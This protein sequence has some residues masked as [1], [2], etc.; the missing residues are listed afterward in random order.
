MIVPD[1][2]KQGLK[3]TGPTILELQEE[4]GGAGNFH[5]P[6]EEHYML[7]KEEWRY[8]KFPEFY[9]GSNV[10]DFYDPDITQK[11]NELEREEEELLRMENLQ[12]DVME[13][14]ESG[15]TLSELKSSL[16]EVRSRKV[17][18]KLNHKLNI[19]SRITQAKKTV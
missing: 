1:S 17:L 6:V 13:E 4:F 5:I 14:P 10:L 19:K 15:V 12:D 18:A 8:D 16:K 7:E 2:V 3:K 11:L 9:N